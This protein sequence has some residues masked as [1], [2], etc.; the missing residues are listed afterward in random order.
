[1]GH[2]RIPTVLP[3]ALAPLIP[4]LCDRFLHDPRVQDLMYKHLVNEPIKPGPIMSESALEIEHLRA[5]LR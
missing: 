2:S 4:V 1:M 5:L 3:G